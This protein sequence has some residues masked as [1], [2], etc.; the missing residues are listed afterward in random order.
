M[1]KSLEVL[2]LR[3]GVLCFIFFAS[4]TSNGQSRY[5]F[6]ILAVKGTV[7]INGSPANVGTS[8]YEGDSLEIKSGTYVGLVHRSG[9]AVEVSYVGVYSTRDLENM[10]SITTDL[11]LRPKNRRSSW[12]RQNKAIH[13]G[14]YTVASFQ[15]PVLFS[16]VTLLWCPDDTITIKEYR[17]EIENMFNDL[18]TSYLTTN[19]YYELDLTDETLQGETALLVRIKSNEPNSTFKSGQI[20]LKKGSPKSIDQERVLE[21]KLYSNSRDPKYW[22]EIGDE[23]ASKKFLYSAL[24]AYYKAMINSQE[25]IYK[26]KLIEFVTTAFNADQ[27]FIRCLN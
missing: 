5:L 26:D 20:L 17:I 24:H 27:N 11:L 1:I 3:F 2:N 10:I 12:I 9:K 6:R 13:E 21:H 23:C 18:L 7:W 8:L 25:A 15:H 14:I 16:K 19:T 22:T 4:L